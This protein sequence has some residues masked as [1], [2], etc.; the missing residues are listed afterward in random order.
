MQIN[1]VLNPTLFLKEQTLHKLSHKKFWDFGWTNRH[2]DKHVDRNSDIDEQFYS[3]QT[4]LH[5]GS[6]G[7]KCAL[8]DPYTLSL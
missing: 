4:T 5:G 3:S 1:R 8:V 6:G 7:W 2:T